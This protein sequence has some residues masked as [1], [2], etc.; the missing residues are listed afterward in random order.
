MYTLRELE[1]ELAGLT[2]YEVAAPPWVRIRYLTSPVRESELEAF[3]PSPPAPGTVLLTRFPHRG[4][5]NRIAADAVARLPLPVAVC[6]FVTIEGHEDEVGDPARF[7]ALGLERALAV[8]RALLT[9]MDALRRRRGIPTP[10]TPDTEITVSSAG[11]FRPIRSNVT[12]DG[13]ALNRRVEV[14]TEVGVCTGVA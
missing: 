3:D 6:V 14:R 13:R 4:V 1:Y 7:G 11:P 9:T 10:S 8:T 2:E 5:I 12:A